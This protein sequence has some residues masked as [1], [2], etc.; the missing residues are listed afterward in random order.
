MCSEAFRLL[1]S[2]IF[3]FYSFSEPR[4]RDRVIYT[5]SLIGPYL[6]VSDRFISILIWRWIR[7]YFSGQYLRYF[8]TVKLAEKFELSTALLSELQ[9]IRLLKLTKAKSTLHYHQFYSLLSNVVSMIIAEKTVI[10]RSNRKTNKQS[11]AKQLMMHMGCMS[12]CMGMT[13]W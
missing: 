13:Y 7:R 5:R 10:I 11:T 6:P 1:S 4:G 8:W 12:T 2:E 9:V 3:S